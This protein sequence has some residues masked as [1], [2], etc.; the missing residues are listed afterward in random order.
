MFPQALEPVARRERGAL[1]SVLVKRKRLERAFMEAEYKMRTI[2]Y[3]NM[4]QKVG[5]LEGGEMWMAFNRGK[6][7]KLRTESA[8]GQKR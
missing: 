8:Q 4:E 1:S 2:Q 3:I 7:G 6:R 5:M